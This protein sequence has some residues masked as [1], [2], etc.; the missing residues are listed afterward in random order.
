[1]CLAVGMVTSGDRAASG[2]RADGLDVFSPATREWFR[3][4]FEQP[5]A[6][7]REAWEAISSG[8]HALV[9][10]PT[11]SGKTLAAF[12]WA[13]DRLLLERSNGREAPPDTEKS[14]RGGTRILYIS[15]LKALGVDVER[16]LYAPLVGITRTARR[17][18]TGRPEI[19]V[20][21]RSGDTSSAERRAQLREPPDILIT[22][23]ESLYLMLTSRAR[24][25]LRGVQTVIVDEVHAVAPSKRGAHLA[26]SLERLDAMLPRPA[27]R[28][29]L[30]ATVRPL[31]EVARFLGGTAP[32]RIVAPAGE[33][34]FDLR[35]VVPV[36]DMSDIP[37]P[38]PAGEDDATEHDGRRGSIWPHLE[39]ELLER[40]LAER[41][42]IVFVNSRRVAERLTG[43]LNE[44]YEDRLEAE[45]GEP[46]TAPER[47]VRSHAFGHDPVALVGDSAVD[48]G[49]PPL[50]ARAHHGS[51]AKQTRAEIEDALKR[52]ALRCVVATSSLELGI[53]MGQVDLVVQI[54][55]A[56]S[57]SSGLQRIGRA[58][59]SVGVV[60]RGAIL[61]KH[62]ADALHSAVVA[63]R[64][65]RGDI[66]AMSV[67]ANPLDVLAQHTVAAAALDELDVEEWFELVRRA[68]PF[69]ALP[70]PLFDATLDLLAG[71]YP[72]DR[73]AELRPRIVWDRD[74]DR[75]AGRPGAQRLAVTSGGTIPDRGTFGV[76]LATGD[77][78][79][80]QQDR[81]PSRRGG[82]RVGELDE[83]MVH[84][85]RTGDVFALGTTSWRITGITHD[86][87]LV[88]PAFG[89]P[90][91]LPFWRG[92]AQGRPAELGEAI[93]ATARRIA[94]T[95]RVPAEVRA[96]CDERAAANIAAY[97]LEQREATGR[98]PSDRTIVIERL[99]DELG[100]HRIVLHSP[101]GTPVHAPW[102]LIVGA[103]VRER[104]GVDA[105]AT[106]A[107]DGIIV[108]IPAGDGEAPGAELFELDPEGIEAAV[109][110]ELGASA[111]FT[112][113][114]R[115]AA[116]RA[117]LLPR[118]HPGRRSPLW[119]QRQKAA[120]LLEVAREHPD[121]PIVLETVREVLHDVYDLDALREL[122]RR[123]RARDVQIAEVRR[124]EPSPYARTLLMG[125]VGAFMYEYDAPLA[126]RRAA[127]LSLDPSLLNELLGDGELRELLDAG[128]IE[129]LER[130]LQRLTPDRLARDSEGVADLLRLLG[131]LSL[132]EI[133]RRLGEPESAAAAAEE[134]VATGRALRLRIA[135][136]EV[137]SAIEDASRLRDAIGTPLPI[138]VP[139]AFLEPVADP[140][141]D[142]VSRYARTHG[143]FPAVRAAE[144][145]G[146]GEAVV[147]E[148]LTRLELGRRVVRGEF[149]PGVRGEEWVD[150]AV[151]RRI[152]G[153]TLAELR[154]QIEPVEQSGFA[155]F[156]PA[157]QHIDG[158]LRG[159]DGVVAAVEQLAGAPIPASAWESFVLPARVADYTPAMLDELLAAGELL[160]HGHGPIGA[161]DGWLSLHLADTA[162]LTLP[163][164]GD[165]AGDPGEPGE[166]DGN[167]L[168]D[169]VLTELETGG[170]LFFRQLAA[171]LQERDEERIADALWRLAWR[172]RIACDGFAPVR[173]L[174][175]GAQGGTSSSAHR[176]ASRAVRGRLH[177][178]RVRMR[179]SGG[180]PSP[181]RGP[182]RASGRWAA[183]GPIP[184]NPAE[185]AIASAEQL[186][187]R[188]GV[189]TRGSVAAEGLAGGFAAAYRVLAELERIGRARRGYLVERL[190]A[191]QFSTAGAI[192]RLRRFAAD[193]GR[194]RPALAAL[195]LAATDPANA[196]G[197]ALDWPEPA[198]QASGRHRPGRR[199]GGLVTLVDGAL[200]LYSE[201]GGRTMLSFTAEEPVLRAACRSLADTVR[202]ARVPG[203]VVERVDGRFALEHEL[204][205][206]LQEAG[207]SAGPRGLRLRTDGAAGRGGL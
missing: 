112:A 16:N 197:A 192:D 106:A 151:L 123:I 3:G 182:A 161:S 110:A 111:L 129:Q 40:V 13:L 56:P 178:G 140:V 1:M 55:A 164:T 66:E 183:N 61:P 26:L 207:F 174:L 154:S 190:G 205:A 73:F 31:E 102:A 200:A 204:G 34:R 168:D 18:G 63:S 121:F 10:A 186:L 202:R 29:G 23:P 136:R 20:A 175:A 203:F 184:A 165:G 100:D 39:A 79:P 116:A 50:L 71:R 87:V 142:L 198:A 49:A 82:V 150:A 43:R 5:T 86:R 42:T 68:A 201:R 57:V 156:L 109:T 108:R 195:T 11:G 99:Q 104:Y 51:V 8:G 15:P 30:S 199:A 131:P 206:L 14:P 126:E 62:R 60:S 181:G 54:E 101:Y 185:R 98:V 96:V 84:E 28:I 38:D 138:G 2:D 45:R 19:T 135:G 27:Q 163:P 167:G 171:Q 80:E 48:A 158:E 85:S 113:R 21:V 107:D 83:E 162:A 75:L 69:A 139:A 176:T 90:G 134:L 191:A 147:R 118:L 94:R 7:Q 133:A 81:A 97:V 93:G 76:Y 25:T 78:G 143:P 160:W 187:D 141:G 144:R 12:L 74:R 17:L 58:G 88:V 130:E 149:T 155:R 196:Y 122:A 47:P 179:P 37:A 120:Q 189:V 95:G 157:W 119:Q 152:R 125:Y 124:E 177:R 41:S 24:E 194:E 127:A 44:L 170:A 89:E 188:Y 169:R 35:V 145:L 46:D 22:T 173:A 67:V 114:F 32:V 146:L 9:V 92:E 172:G 153:R 166:A 59:H 159:L 115:E 148:A 72:S 64:M 180:T 33:K 128:V 52:G 103:R 53:D 91:R 36:E 132:E 137:L 77:E 193:P 105:G 4:A 65:L 117:L 70:R 6:A